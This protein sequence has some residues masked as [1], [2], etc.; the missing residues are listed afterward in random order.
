MPG[1]QSLKA[2]DSTAEKIMLNN[3]A[4]RTQPCLTPPRTRAFME[5]ADDCDERAWLPEC[6]HDFPES[7]PIVCT[8]GL[9][10]VNEGRVEVTMLFHAFFLELAGGK[11]RVGCSTT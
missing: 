2:S 11:D 5:L 6:F 8:E 1:S 3:V 10:Q 9:V 4:A 7:A